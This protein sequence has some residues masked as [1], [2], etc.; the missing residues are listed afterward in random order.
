MDMARIRDAMRSIATMPVQDVPTGIESLIETL[1][2][3]EPQATEPSDS[4][5]DQVLEEPAPPP[6]RMIPWGARAVR[7]HGDNFMEGIL[8]IE[9]QI[10]LKPEFLVPCMQFESRLDPKARNPL[11]SASGLIQ[12]M[13]QTALNLGTTIT[14]IRGLD[15]MGQLAYVYKYFKD[16]Y[17][18]GHKLNH[19]DLADTYMAILWP[20]GIGR[21]MDHPIFVPGS[22]AYAVNWGLDANRDGLVTK[23]EAAA[24]VTQTAVEGLKDMNVLQIPVSA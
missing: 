15:A 18:R 24:K 1:G 12:F 5:L 13:E 10:G 19:W 3:S 17:D 2:L 23:A 9:N 21:P 8:W 20:A 7:M 11:S 22:K 4:P 14:R 16:F 6:T